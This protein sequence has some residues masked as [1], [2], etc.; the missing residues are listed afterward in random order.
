MTDNQVREGKAIVAALDNAPLGRQH[1]LFLAALL[2]ALIFDY[3]KPT[4]ISFVIPGMRQMWNLSAVEGSYLAVAGLTGTVIGSIFWGF[5]ADRIGRRATLLWTVA[6]FSV[7]CLC[8]LA[9]EFWNSLLACFVMGLGVG[10][11]TPIVFSLAAEYIPARSRGRTLLFLGMVGS[12]AGYVFAATLAT[13]LRSLT[14]EVNVWRFMW[15]AQLL[16]GVM[17][18]IL[19]SKIVPESARYLIQNGRIEEA[20]RAA[21]MMIGSIRPAKEIAPETERKVAPP[22][23]AAP[24]LYGRT[25]ALSFFSFAAG[26]ANFGFVTWAPTLLGDVGFKPGEASGF[27]A[28]SALFALPALLITGIVLDRRG[29]RGTLVAFAVGGGLTLVTLGVGSYTGFLTPLFVVVVTSAFFFF[30]TSIGGAFSFYGAEVFPTAM[31]VRRAGIVAALGKFGGVV[32]P[33][34]GGLW[35]ASGG[36]WL[37]LQLPLALALIT[38]AV[39]LAITGVETHKRTLEQIAAAS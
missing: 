27:L 3:S 35:L 31:R 30:N 2:G 17:I 8:G 20:R 10:G 24:R 33:Y 19:R 16:P 28:L 21:E 32:G 25:V 11:E 36:N 26:L 9:V 12:L 38:A 6:I 18:L 5:M 39:V 15:L 34:L 14:A 22:R 1:K 23:E 7:A 4:T 37:G 13:V 29:T